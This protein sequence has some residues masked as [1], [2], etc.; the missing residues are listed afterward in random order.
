MVRQICTESVRPSG[1]RL[2]TVNYLI[3]TLSRKVSGALQ[4]L[5][6][7]RVRASRIDRISQLQAICRCNN[8][9]DPRSC[10]H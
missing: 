8:R 10:Q 6:A 2:L 4:R 1:K 3:C 9:P 7:S 5:S